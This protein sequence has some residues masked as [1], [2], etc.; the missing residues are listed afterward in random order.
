MK[1]QVRELIEENTYYR[2]KERGS[3][4]ELKSEVVELKKLVNRF[5]ESLTEKDMLIDNLRLTNKKVN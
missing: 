5:G 2:S 3:K 4:G 1:V